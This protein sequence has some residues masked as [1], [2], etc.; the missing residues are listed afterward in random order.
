MPL[1]LIIECCKC[2][3]YISKD[4]W[5]IKR[6]HGYNETKRLC[7]HFSVNIDHISS[8]GFFGLGWS[9]LI[10]VTV[11]RYSQT[12]TLIKKTFR[13]NDTEYQHY[14]RFDKIV[15]HARV[16]DSSGY[17]PTCGRDEQET[18]EF[19]ER[20]EQQEREEKKRKYERDLKLQIAKMIEKGSNKEEK[21][22]NKEKNKK[23]EKK[24]TK[25]KKRH[26][27]KYI[28]LNFDQIYDTVYEKIIAK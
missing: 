14:V 4:I 9:N 20:R 28:N 23:K 17:W 7:S 15:V 19:N 5:S 18:I 1:H 22:E 3:G 6:D 21:I 11:T 24:K 10:T 13:K 16:S 27:V 26:H 8:I 25:N 2:K 12:K